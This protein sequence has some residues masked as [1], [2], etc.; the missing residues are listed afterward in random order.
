MVGRVARNRPLIDAALV[1]AIGREM[2][3]IACGVNETDMFRKH[4]P[5]EQRDIIR[6]GTTIN[7]L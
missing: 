1:M 7:R 6:H 5:Y 3:Y 2:M 4:T